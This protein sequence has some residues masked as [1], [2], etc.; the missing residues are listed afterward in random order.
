MKALLCCITIAITL[1]LTACTDSPVD[2]RLD[3]ADSLME[4]RPDS[5]L[6][7][8]DSISAAD[9]RGDEQK[10][11]HALLLS[12][13]LDKNYIDTTT[14]DVLQPA[15]DYYPRHGSPDEKL[16]TYYYQGRIYQNRSEYND[17][18]LRYMEACDLRGKITDSLTLAR[19][20]VAQGWLYREQQKTK[21]FKKNNL[22]A[23]EIFHAYDMKMQRFR[24]YSRALE[25]CLLTESKLG[26]DSVLAL[27]ISSANDIEN[28]YC[29][30]NHKA[31]SPTF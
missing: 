18:M 27:C 28:Y 19:T 6:T 22:E 10:A 26:A 23:A 17:A 3:L 11:R 16:R 30:L 13:A 20:L 15:I 8:L 14:F 4:S 2:A 29:P 1:A 31:V 9:L 5:A 21:L 7:I 24:C 25:A 12:M